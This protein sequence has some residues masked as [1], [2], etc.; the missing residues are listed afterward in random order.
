MS[1]VQSRSSVPQPKRRKVDDPEAE[2]NGTS[3]PVRSGGGGILGGYVKE[4]QKEA[5]GSMA[6]PAMTVDLTDGMSR[7][8]APILFASTR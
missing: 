6:S 5:N 8:C 4:K 7:H 3:V 1:N 2:Q